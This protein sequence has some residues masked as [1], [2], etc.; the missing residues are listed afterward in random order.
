MVVMGENFLG[1]IGYGVK[2]GQMGGQR[3]QMF[4]IKY[5]Q[6]TTEIIDIIYIYII[7]TK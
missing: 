1:E 7:K 3:V 4:L 5:I 6:K 2:I